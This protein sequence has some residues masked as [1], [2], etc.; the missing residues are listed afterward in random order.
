M[1]FPILKQSVIAALE[2]CKAC[3]WREKGWV[4]GRTKNVR[5]ETKVLRQESSMPKVLSVVDNE[6]VPNIRV[7]R[8]FD[9]TVLALMY[10][11]ER[12]DNCR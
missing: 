6:S 7:S 10:V 3:E 11:M 4:G 5:R 1:D 2:V 12:S 9:V 8:G